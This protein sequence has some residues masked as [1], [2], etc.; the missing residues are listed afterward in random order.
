MFINLGNYKNP[1]FFFFFCSFHFVYVQVGG[2]SLCPLTK[3][4]KKT[5]TPIEIS[6]QPEIIHWI[7]I[8]NSQAFYLDFVAFIQTS[9]DI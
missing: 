6:L 8:V 3:K 5:K 7:L 2:L 1:C 4:K 9:L